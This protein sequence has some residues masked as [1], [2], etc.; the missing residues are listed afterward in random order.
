MDDDRYNIRPWNGSGMRFLYG[1][2]DTD[3]TE[4]EDSDGPDAWDDSEEEPEPEPRAEGYAERIERLARQGLGG[5]TIG[6]RAEAEG[7]EALEERF[8][9][10]TLVE[11]G[12]EF[13]AL[14]SQV[15]EA[16]EAPTQGF[17]HI[18]I[19]VKGT[20]FQEAVWREL[21]RIPAGETRSYADIAAAVGKPKAVRAAGSANG[22]N[23][24]AVLIP[25]HR[26]VRKGGDLGGY[27]YGQD[28]KRELLRREEK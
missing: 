16:V 10:A 12:E 22:A 27:A 1:D 28:I 17:D 21:R 24:V 26:V 9:A 23:N 6:A 3:D 7:R 8:P 15:I 5:T 18:P 13:A 11:G 25:C 2:D 14:L 4:D 20:A 19:D